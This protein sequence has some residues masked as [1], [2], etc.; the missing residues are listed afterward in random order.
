[1]LRLPAGRW[2]TG[3]LAHECFN[4]MERRGANWK[5]PH[6]GLQTVDSMGA[7]TWPDTCLLRL[8]CLLCVLPQVFDPMMEGLTTAGAQG[9]PGQPTTQFLQVLCCTTPCNASSDACFNARCWL[10]CCCLSCCCYSGAAQ[11]L[12]ATWQPM[13]TCPTRSPAPLA[14]L[15]TRLLCLLCLPADECRLCH[16]P[17]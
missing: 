14:P 17:G 12:A 1:M 9:A 16:G 6:A 13:P 7:H 5:I 3:G 4:R 2:A 11:E 15:P 10:S 8:L